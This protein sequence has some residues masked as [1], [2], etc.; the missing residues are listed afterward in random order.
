MRSLSLE[1]V[2]CD[3]LSEIDGDELFFDDVVDQNC[4]FINNVVFNW[5]R[6]RILK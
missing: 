2:N 1:G 3:E 6:V 5:Q 4:N